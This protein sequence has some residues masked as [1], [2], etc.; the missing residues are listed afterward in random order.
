M[1]KIWILILFLTIVLSG[2]VGEKQQPW[3]RIECG[4]DDIT[5]VTDFP[6]LFE[7]SISGDIEKFKG[8]NCT[9]ESSPNTTIFANSFPDSGE[10]NLSF[11]DEDFFKIPDYW[12]HFYFHFSQK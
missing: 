9:V 3:A 2:C 8:D 6:V 4:K 10:E 12:D 1:K 5:V 11:V 7:P